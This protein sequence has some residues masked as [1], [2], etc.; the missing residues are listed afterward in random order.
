MVRSSVLSL[1]RCS[2]YDRLSR[3]SPADRLHP[4]Q[5]IGSELNGNFVL[6]RCQQICAGRQLK[7]YGSS[8]HTARMRHTNCVHTS[9]TLCVINICVITR[10]ICLILRVIG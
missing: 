5:N 8:V 10:S 9:L 2:K 1:A 7:G 4:Q 6:T 3:S